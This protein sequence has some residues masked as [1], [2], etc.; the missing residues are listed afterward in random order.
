MTFEISEYIP[1]VQPDVYDAVCTNIEIIPPKGTNTEYRRWTFS[2]LDGRTVP[3][4]TSM[5]NTP[6]SKAGKWAAALAGRT[7]VVGDKP[8]LIGAPCKIVVE[9]NDNGYERVI[10]V[11]PRQAAPVHRTASAEAVANSEGTQKAADLKAGQE[12]DPTHDP[13][14]LPF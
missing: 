3:G 6:G 13:D 8:V 2:L 11:L 9:L 12:E 4:T 5:Q 1:T 14:A 7:L 10:N